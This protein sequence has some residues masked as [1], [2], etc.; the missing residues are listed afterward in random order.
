MNL[1]TVVLLG[2]AVVWA[3]VLAPEVLRRT[4]G[5][6]RVDPVNAFHRQMSSLDRNGGRPTGR[7]GT[8]VIDLRGPARTAPRPM[9]RPTSAR[10]GGAPQRPAGPV[11]RPAPRAVVSPRT[12]KR[13]QDVLIVLV[14]AAV[15]TLLCAVAFGGAFLLLHLLADVLLVGYVVLLNRSAQMAARPRRATYGYSSYGQQIDLRTPRPQRP[16]PVAVPG[17]RRVAN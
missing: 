2:L 12:Q 8:N 14:A 9:Q 16:Q 11:R 7:P 6:R 17:T 10:Y 4:S 3:I 15:L 13:R 1:S 5:M